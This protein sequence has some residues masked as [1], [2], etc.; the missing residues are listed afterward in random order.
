VFSHAELTITDA[1]VAASNIVLAQLAPSVDFDADDLSDVSVVAEATDGA[2]LVTISRDGP[3]GG[4]YRIL[5]A[6]GTP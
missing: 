4:T 5:Y 3:I 6:V 1:S 2:V